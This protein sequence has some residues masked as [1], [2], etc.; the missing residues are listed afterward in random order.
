MDLHNA[1]LV[2]NRKILKLK[3]VE[4][5]PEYANDM[6]LPLTT[7]PTSSPCQTPSPLAARSWDSLSAARRPSHLLFCHR[8]AYM[9]NV[10]HPFT[11]SLERRTLI[12]VVLLFSHPGSIVQSDCGI[13]H[14]ISSRI[15]KALLA[16]Q[17]LS[18]ISWLQRK[19]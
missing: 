9:S 10:Q 12:E 4:T 3:T 18:R 19:I 11:W 6:A 15:C 16:F 1:D 7:N 8:R 2:G 13:G 14:K 5:D 17:S